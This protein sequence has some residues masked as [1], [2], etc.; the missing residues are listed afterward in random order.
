MLLLVL[1][2]SFQVAV[3]SDKDQL[4]GPQSASN[5]GCPLTN[6]SRALKYNEAQSET[7]TDD[8]KF[9]IFASAS[10][11]VLSLPSS[12]ADKPQSLP[13]LFSLNWKPRI[14][15]HTSFPSPHPT[16]SG[17]PRQLQ[18][19][20]QVQDA[21]PCI[22]TCMYV[23]FFSKYTHT[24]IHVCVFVCMCVYIYMLWIS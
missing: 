5:G 9:N 17:P 15:C 13:S 19:V 8:N 12:L 21:N 1:P 23:S 18:E 20:R 24:H 4:P 3:P 16:F 6:I 22:Q 11:Q 2:R 7:T 14:C 10:L